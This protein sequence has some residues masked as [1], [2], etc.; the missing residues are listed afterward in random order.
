MR[1]RFAPTPSGYLHEGNAVN[2]VLTSW[3]ARQ[4]GAD[5][6]LRIDDV[7]AARCR[8]EFVEDIFAVLE[9]L[10]VPWALGPRTAADFNDHHSQ[11]ARTERYRVELDAAMVAGLRVY[12]CRCSR[13]ESARMGRRGCVADCIDADH[14]LVKGETALRARLPDVAED[15]V[16]WRRDGLP[17]YHLVSVI[18]DRQLGTTHIVRGLDLLDSTR[19]Q[20]ALG[21]YLGMDFARVDVRHHSLVQGPDGAK[22][23]KSQLSDGPLERSEAARQRVFRLAGTM[24]AS[25]AIDEPGVPT[26]TAAARNDTTHPVTGIA[27]PPLH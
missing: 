19:L 6:A 12:A 13:A 9:W 11:R 7:D 10:G 22:L 3:L 16:V 26:V 24:A 23:S 14:S 15:P 8:P 17:A 18:E 20:A 4:V 27:A 2:A 21:T 1:T 5:V 25:V